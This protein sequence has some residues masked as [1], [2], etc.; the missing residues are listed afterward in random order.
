ML[1]NVCIGDWVG[2]DFLGWDWKIMVGIGM[3]DVFN[4]VMFKD[5]LVIDEEY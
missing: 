5:F 3:F 2:F 1:I 4:F